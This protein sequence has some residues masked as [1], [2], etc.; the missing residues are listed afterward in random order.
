MKRDGRFDGIWGL[1]KCRFMIFTDS[2]YSSSIS[3]ILLHPI[4]S[5]LCHCHRSLWFISSCAT[6]LRG[7]GAVESIIKIHFY[8]TTWTERIQSHPIANKCWRSCKITSPFTSLTVAP[9]VWNCDALATACTLHTRQ[10]ERAQAHRFNPKSLTS[11][12]WQFHCAI[13]AECVR[14][15]CTPQSQMKMGTISI[16]IKTIT[17]MTSENLFKNKPFRFITKTTNRICR[18]PALHSFFSSLAVHLSF[19]SRVTLS[20]GAFVLCRSSC[21]EHSIYTDIFRSSLAGAGMTHSKFFHFDLC[22]QR[23]EK[24]VE[25]IWTKVI[26]GFCYINENGKNLLTESVRTWSSNS[27]NELIILL[28]SIDIVRTQCLALA[29]R[30]LHSIR[31]N[32]MWSIGDAS[33]LSLP[34]AASWTMNEWHRTQT[35]M[36]WFLPRQRHSANIFQYCDT[37][38]VPQFFSGFFHFTNQFLPVH[39]C[40]IESAITIIRLLIININYSVVW[41]QMTDHDPRANRTQW[42]SESIHKQKNGKKIGNFISKRGKKWNIFSAA[43][44]FFFL[45]NKNHF[46][47][48][49]SLGRGKLCHI[50]R[51]TVSACNTTHNAMPCTTVAKLYSGVANVKW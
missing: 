42:K 47:I 7:M 25:T 16:S 23:G 5:F 6:A 1:I 46:S 4:S 35:T 26:L 11:C 45:C 15:M 40:C 19:L 10:K 49:L 28:A 41:T 33:Q 3:R 32:E 9:H 43:F 30:H 17:K 51:H 27:S 38:E 37:D 8:C 2:V 48:I 24:E 22:T 34:S 12:Y 13:C 31:S 36:K 50:N 21:I 20:F 18:C 39:Y 44:F 29:H 14:A